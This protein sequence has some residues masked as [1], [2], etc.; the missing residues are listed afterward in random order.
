M[1][2][3]YLK[4]AF[5]NLWRKKV[6]TFINILGLSIG[7]ACCL[8]ILMHIRDDFSYDK[9]HTKANQVYRMALER[10]YPD[11]VSK[12]AIIPAGFADVLVQDIPEIE[13]VVRLRTAFGETIIQIEDQSY[14]E[15]QVMFADSGFFHL[16]SIPLIEGNPEKALAEPNKVVL[17]E[18]TA[19]K[20]FGDEKAIGKVLKT[21]FGDLIVSGVCE[22]VPSNTHFEFD[23]LI[24]FVSQGFLID[25]PQYMSFSSVTY[26]LLNKQ[27]DPQNVEARFPEIVEKYASGQIQR[28]LGMSY[29]QYV[30]AGNGYHY[31][32]QALPDIY[33]HS[34]LEGELKP[35]GD[36]K[37]VYLFSSIAIFILLI[38]CINFMN[39]ATARSADRAKEVGVRKVMGAFRS[40]LV[41]QFLTEAI[42]ISFVSLGFALVL[43]QMALPFFNEFAGKNL[44][45]NTD[46]NLAWIP[47]M[48]LFAAFVG[49]LAGSYPAFVLSG[50]KPVSVLKG[51]FQHSKAG[52]LLRKGLVVFQ[53]AISI[54]LIAATM[55]V[56]RQMQFMQNK[57][58]GFD[59]EQVLVI[60]RL[61]SLQAPE[62]DKSET[63]RKIVAQMPEVISAGMANSMPGNYFY[64]IQFQQ[65]GGGSDVF[66]F[67]GMNVDDHYFESMQMEI[68]QGRAFSEAFNDT[69]A[70]I[71]NEHAIH[72]LGI[73]DPIGKQIIQ[74]G[75]N[76]QEAQTY[77]IV[78]VVK[79]FH[80]QSMHENIGSLAIL[81]DE[82]V[83]SFLAFMPVRFQTGDINGFIS[84][85]EDK[86][87]QFNVDIP[88]AYHFL[89]EELN[90][91]YEN[92][93][94]TGKMFGL[95]AI[96]AIL[97]ACIGL[98]GLSAFV[99]Q[100]RRKEIGVRK[101]LG[102]SIRQI[103]MLLTKE[104]SLLIFVSLIFAIPVIWFG[105]RFW[106]ESFAYHIQLG[107]GVFFI[108]GFI[109]LAVAW[110]TIGYQ[111][112]KAA[113]VNPV[114]SLRD[115]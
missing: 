69:L 103:I 21:P 92:E 83:N 33:L 39:L 35:T 86:W 77:T 23:L 71:F 76:P 7:I 99:A 26:L 106:L 57:D 115:E 59:E 2:E 29:A 25:N 107:V 47:L 30:E 4:T 79:D 113:V 98:L 31:F 49:L 61:G 14:E 94:R 54:I 58:L 74:P 34:R 3:N 50:F 64:G 44:V 100:Q 70:V 67:R 48:V 89:D 105:M 78:G 1:W 87:K 62:N 16:F 52:N 46:E 45:L 60:E 42:L 17:T 53:F 11:H 91:L 81:S 6:Y 24:S 65:P 101:V 73:Q 55:T 19:H 84:T 32:L 72:E 68:V 82:S 63:F 8:L 13:E 75:N 104:F 93:S 28:R 66:T 110:L 85:L 114:E 22:D 40:M 12:Y 108:S 56:Y 51:K 80:Y 10:I 41:S 109:A 111:S 27:A 37:S 38:A 102:A 18:S 36:I 95:F 90:L 88:F 43:I 5:R 9:Y 20:Y 15:H 96:L 112:I 97:V